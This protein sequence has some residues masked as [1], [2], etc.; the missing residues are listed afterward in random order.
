MKSTIINN[1]NI[2]GTLPL[3]RRELQILTLLSEGLRK[4]QISDQLGISPSTVATH[5]KNIYHKLGVVNVAGAIGLA[6]RSGILKLN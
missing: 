3:S 5:A 4:H 6:F 1:S 2:Q